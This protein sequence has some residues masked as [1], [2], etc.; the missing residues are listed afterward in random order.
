MPLSLG[1]VRLAF[2]SRDNPVIAKQ[3]GMPRS[4][5]D[6][7]RAKYKLGDLMGRMKKSKGK[8]SE[9]TAAKY[10][11]QRRPSLRDVLNQYDAFGLLPAQGP[12]ESYGGNPV[13][14]NPGVTEVNRPPIQLRRRR[15]PYGPA[16]DWGSTSSGV[17]P[18][19]LVTGAPYRGAV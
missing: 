19:G 17:Q 16:P 2:A 18:L 12:T 13:N 4:L 5:A 8:V 1:Q 7:W 14:L 11:D 10:K 9:K 3:S 15:R 6:E